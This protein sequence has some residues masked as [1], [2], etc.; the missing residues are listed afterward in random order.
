MVLS[1]SDGGALILIIPYALCA[2]EISFTGKHQHVLGKKDGTPMKNNIDALKEAFPEWDGR[3][4]TVEDIPLRDGEEPEF[5]LADCFHDDSYIPPGKTEP[6]VQFK[7]QWFNPIGGSTNMPAPMDDAQKKKVFT[8]W[9]G[10]FKALSGSAPAA[11]STP[12]AAQ[13]PAAVSSPAPAKKAAAA[14]PSSRRAGSPAVGGQPRTSSQSEVWNAFA[15]AND[16]ST[17]ELI[18]ALSARYYDAQEEVRA[19][20]DGNLT[21]AEWGQ[22]A[23]KLG[24]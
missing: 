3:I 4:E 14:G 23:I 16:T 12:A 24:V 11:K 10:K 7:A 15:A 9:G 13:Q 1:E 2:G 22:V 19:N 21:P 5:E 6:I 17:Q 8:K 18:D 20:A